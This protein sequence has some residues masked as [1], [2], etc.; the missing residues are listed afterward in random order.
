MKNNNT[1]TTQK[2]GMS[3]FEVISIILIGTFVW[4]AQ[5][6]YTPI[7]ISVGLKTEAGLDFPII[8]IEDKKPDNKLS[9]AIYTLAVASDLRLR[10]K[11]IVFSNVGGTTII[12]NK[13]K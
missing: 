6:L 3:G 12:L 4:F 11:Y 13:A 1:S 10:F 9:E 2:S 5:I 7:G 8:F